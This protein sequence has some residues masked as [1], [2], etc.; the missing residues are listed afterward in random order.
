M[1][2]PDAPELRTS[3]LAP[4]LRLAYR[5]TGASRRWRVARRILALALRLEGGACRSATAR[6]LLAEHHGVEV[7]AHSYG[8][9]LF[10][11]AL[12]PPGVRVGRYASVG[13]GV[14][15]ILRNH[16]VDGVSTHPYFYDPRLRVVAADPLPPGRLEIGHDAWIGANAVVLPGCKRIGTG[17]VVAAGAVVTKDV[18]DFAV[19]GG[20]PARVLRYRFSSPAIER[21]RVSKWWDRTPDELAPLAASLREP[22]DPSAPH[23]VLPLPAGASS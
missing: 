11:P 19:V 9:A 3:R 6:R 21:V 12:A 15:F 8:E 13:P 5:V 23:P 2:G 1:S 7:G 17:A 20:V 22:F 16:P 14:R 10:D 4:L 18:P